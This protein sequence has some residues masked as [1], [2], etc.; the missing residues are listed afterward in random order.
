MLLLSRFYAAYFRK[1]EVLHLA[2]D[3]VTIVHTEGRGVEKW[4]RGQ[5]DS[6]DMLRDSE[7]ARRSSRILDSNASQALALSA[8]IPQCLER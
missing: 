5:R 7:H 3:V 1:L 2:I 6:L 8:R 4:V